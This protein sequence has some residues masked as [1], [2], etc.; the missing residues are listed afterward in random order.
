V[1]DAEPVYHSQYVGQE[2]RSIKSLS[3]QDIEELQTGKG[4]GLAKAAE[5]NGVPGPSH[6]LEMAEEIHLTP[7]QR[8]Q[9]EQLYTA[10]TDRAIPLG[11]Q[12]VALEQELNTAFAERSMT[13]EHL[14]ELLRAI[15]DVYQQLR[16]VH[17]SAHL[18]TPEILT[19]EQI[20]SYN[21]LRG[22]SSA[23]PC[24]NIPVGHDADM[25]KLHNNCP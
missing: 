24:N 10:M 7:I 22:Y 1:G 6:L 16:Y 3:D 9:I 13:D 18:K 5:L 11:Q 25:W 21:A 14:Q 20:A 19:S 8:Q 12:L 17:L 4:W 2:Q 23:D 15:A